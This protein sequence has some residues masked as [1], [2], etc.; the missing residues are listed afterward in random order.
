MDFIEVTEIEN[1]SSSI[2]NSSSNNNSIQKNILSESPGVF[3]IDKYITDE[4]CQHMITISKPTM[5]DSL[6][7]DN[8]KR[9]HIK[10]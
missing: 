3:T 6:V 1:N 4:E 5:K 2:D 8:K 10:G 7:S 9:Y